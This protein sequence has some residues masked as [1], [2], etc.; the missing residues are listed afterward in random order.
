M[1]ELFPGAS[2]CCVTLSRFVCV[3]LLFCLEILFIVGD[4]PFVFFTSQLLINKELWI[5]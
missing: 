2:Q 3:A 4:Y 5:S 1:P